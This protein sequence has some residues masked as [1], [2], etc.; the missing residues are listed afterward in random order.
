MDIV[1]NLFSKSKLAFH[2]RKSSHGFQFKSL[3]GIRG[4]AVG[5]VMVGHYCEDLPLDLGHVGMGV[6]LFFALSSFLLTFPF[7]SKESPLYDYKVWLHYFLRRFL[8]IYPAYFVILVIL[9]LYTRG[10]HEFYGYK[11]NTSE[12]LNHLLLLNGY[13]VFWTMPVELKFYLLLPLLV[14]LFRVIYR[15]NVFNVVYSGCLLCFV[16]YFVDIYKSVDLLSNMFVFVMG[17]CTALAYWRSRDSSWF[18][19]P[20]VK[21]SCEASSWAILLYVVLSIPAIWEFLFINDF[22]RVI[23]SKFLH[24]PLWCIFIFCHLN[25]VGFLRRLC[26]FYPLRFIGFISFS[27]YLFHRLTFLILKGKFQHVGLDGEVVVAA[28][29]FALTGIIAT[30]SYL[31]VEYPFMQLRVRTKNG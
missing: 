13:D 15:E 21:I 31:V 2:T 16:Y 7:Y 28:L 8:R 23:H 1:K 27:L 14:I 29:V 10:G 24:A 19:K 11:F 20:A 30:V 18:R 9:W 22:H 6:F 25:G 26:S 3:D 17:A 5:F 12:V 4:L